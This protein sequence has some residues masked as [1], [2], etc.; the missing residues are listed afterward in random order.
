MSIQCRASVL[1]SHANRS[2]SGLETGPRA[3]SRLLLVQWP[4]RLL[5]SCFLRS[6]WVG[7]K[8]QGFLGVHGSRT[9]LKPLRPIGCLGWPHVKCW[10][11]T[12]RKDVRLH[13]FRRCSHL[14]WQVMQPEAEREIF[15]GDDLKGKS[16]FL[17]FLEMTSMVNFQIWET[18]WLKPHKWM[19][20]SK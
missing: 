13:F 17:S 19:E 7:V 18:F 20:Q 8:Q 4:L 15:F 14:I 10:C 3:P 16:P 12:F 11:P 5:A 9:E 6:S 2:D 1:Q